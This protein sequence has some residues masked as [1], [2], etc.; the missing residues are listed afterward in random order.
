[1]TYVSLIQPR[2][3]P[4]LCHPLLLTLVSLN[5]A[6]AGVPG[7]AGMVAFVLTYKLCERGEATLPIYLVDKGVPVSSLA[8]WNGVVRSV[9]N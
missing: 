4:P 3:Q 7:T 5:I 6:S 9:S 2:H 8:F 1:M